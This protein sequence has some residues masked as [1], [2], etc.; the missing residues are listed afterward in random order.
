MKRNLLQNVKV[1][2]YASGDVIERTG[3]L[4]GILGAKIGTTGTL[5]LT[6]THCDTADGTFEAVPDERLFP[7]KKIT[8][9]VN[10]VEGLTAD[11]IVNIDVDLVGCKNFVK[12]TASGTAATS[13]T[14]AL[15]LGDAAVQP[16]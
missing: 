9:G 2:P 11:D 7:D 4:S 5:T 3:F 1:Q 13:T 6:V 16:V 12:I 15:A 14:F 10:N 8:G